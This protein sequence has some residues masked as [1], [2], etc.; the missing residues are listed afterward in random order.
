LH[1]ISPFGGNIAVT[2]AANIGIAGLTLITGILAARLLGPDGRGTLAAIQTWPTFLAAIATLGLPDATVYF[3]ARDPDRAGRF[4][5][6]AI[7]LS[8]LA[9]APFVAIGY[10][11]MP[12]L[13]AAQSPETVAYARQYLWLIPV[14]AVMGMSFHPLRGRNDL[15]AWNVVRIS[16][17]VG[18]LFLLLAAWHFQILSAGWIAVAY[19]VVLAALIVPLHA[20][21]RLRVPGSFRP[22]VTAWRPMLRYGLS[23]IA[24]SIP[25]ILNVRLDQ[26]I[27]VGM[28][29]PGALGLYAIAA[30]WSAALFPLVGAV[31]SVLF[32]RVAGQVGE[33]ERVASLSQGT[34]LG[35][36]ASLVAAS[37][38]L[39]ATPFAIPLLFGTAFAPAI[40]AGLILVAAAG[41]AGLNGI[42]QEGARGL[43]H[44]I[45]ILWSEG[46]GVVVG[47]SFLLVL[48]PL[49]GIVGAAMAS[50][51]GYSVTTAVLVYSIG[52]I[53]GCGP[54]ALICPNRGDLMMLRE[55]IRALVAR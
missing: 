52:R 40:P 42:L 32:P 19:V 30:S 35:S 48:L 15:A 3:S 28:L 44:P 10:V 54:M 16:P 38:V 12:H 5:T 36:V 20:I 47:V 53:T 11:L 22:D 29:A 17:T 6:S 2:L 34:R 43:G 23:S 45:V 27:M 9:S 8:L 33:R 50:L 13:L 39:V 14:L 25:Q 21:V 46:L 26:M 4:M 55:R 7:I 37:I 24:G 1:E 31:G 49:Y 41:V 51:V 18:W